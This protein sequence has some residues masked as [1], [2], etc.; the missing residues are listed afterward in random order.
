MSR[1]GDPKLLVVGPVSLEF[2]RAWELQG[3]ILEARIAGRI[4]DVLLLVE[5][6]PVITLGRAADPGNVL[7]DREGLAARGIGLFEID[8]GGDVTWH[9]PG[10]LVG[11]P[12]LDLAACPGLGKDVHRW[13]RVLEDVLIEVLAE[14]GIE[15]GRVAGRT[16]V[17][18]GGAKVAA[19]GVKVKRWV[20]MHGFAL[21]VSCDLAG[22][23]A[24]VPCGIADAGVT[25][26][27]ALGGPVPGLPEVGGKV[28]DRLA[29]RAGLGLE[30]VELGELEARAGS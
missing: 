2:G 24:I 4:G 16:G 28:A 12:I 15:G 1:V 26:M 9:G 19:L 22:F 17:W 23:G 7:T 8:R 25:S 29:R 18:V 6:P 27:A 20:T 5:H 10:Q 14:Y 30:R 11:Y 21:N 13:L 3:R